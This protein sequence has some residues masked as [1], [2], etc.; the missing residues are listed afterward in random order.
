MSQAIPQ[1]EV[2]AAFFAAGIPRPQGSKRAFLHK[3]TQKVVMVEGG[4]AAMKKKHGLWRLTLS[5]AARQA[6]AGRPPADGC[7]VVDVE[8]LFPRPKSHYRAN[9]ELKAWAIDVPHGKKPDR[10]KLDRALGDSLTGVVL[11]DDC[12]SNGGI[13]RRRFVMPGEEPGARVRVM[14]ACACAIPKH[15]CPK[16]GL[17]T[18]L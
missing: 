15:L 8:F 18:Q 16:H 14:V 2:V 9:G 17:E 3:T 5:I 6:M 12:Q 11:G 7:V 4:D 1:P 13:Q 10:D